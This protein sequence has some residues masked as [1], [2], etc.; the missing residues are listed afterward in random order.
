MSFEKAADVGFAHIG[1]YE[2]A[3]TMSEMMI[4]HIVSATASTIR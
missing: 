4:A 2:S 3:Q 1:F